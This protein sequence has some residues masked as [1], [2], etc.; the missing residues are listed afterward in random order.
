MN[1][2][3]LRDLRMH[4]ANHC[5]EECGGTN[6]LSMHHIVNK[7]AKRRKNSE[8]WFESVRIL[9][10]DCHIGANSYKVLPKLVKEFDEYLLNYYDSE[11]VREITGKK[12]HI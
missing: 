12:I 7:D 4:Y 9:C 8:Q 10:Y 11:Q 2:K 3:K 6:N 1:T 5:C